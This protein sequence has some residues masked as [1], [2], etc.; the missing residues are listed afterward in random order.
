MEKRVEFHQATITVL[1]RIVDGNRSY[2]V[3]QAQISLLVDSDEEWQVARKQ[4]QA[5]MAQLQEQLDADG[6]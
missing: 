4:I 1:F 2:G 3:K 5:A 6:D